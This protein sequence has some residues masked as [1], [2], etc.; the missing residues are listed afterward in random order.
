VAAMVVVFALGPIFGLPLIRRYVETPAV[1]LTLFYGLA[2]CGWLLLP[3][4]SRSRRNWKIAAVVAIALSAAYLPWHARML[5]GV[6]RRLDVD[7][8]RYSDLQAAAEAPAVVNAFENCPPLTVGDHRPLPYMR[9]WL[10]GE[11][12][13]VTTVEGDA[14]PMG[15]A[16]LMPVRGPTTRRIYT[17]ET[18]PRVEIPAGWS[19]IYRNRSWRVYAP[20][21]C[22]Q[23]GSPDP[24]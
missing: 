24:G 23:P 10:D 18:F 21:E 3:A 8:A 16:L 15:G 11:P 1:L 6:E 13:S 14:D 5:S 17:R 20:S 9:Y 2:V 12:G 7:G 19:T 4:G 22:A